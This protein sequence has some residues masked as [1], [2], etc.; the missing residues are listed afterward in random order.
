MSLSDT[1]R[2]A[3]SQVIPATLESLAASTVTTTRYSTALGTAGRPSTAKTNPITDAQWYISEITDAQT[4]RGWGLNSAA[5]AEALIPIG[6]DV[7]PNDVVRVTAG[8]FAGDTYEVEQLR[9]DPLANMVAVALKPTGK[10][11][12]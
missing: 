5:S 2:N 11:G 6:A 12:L 7:Q 4:Q 1:I 9:R 10:S 8:D 3:T